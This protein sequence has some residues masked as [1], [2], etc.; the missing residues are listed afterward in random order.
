MWPILSSSHNHFASDETADIF[1]QRRF[2]FR[3]FSFCWR[4]GAVSTT[5]ANYWPPSDRNE[6]R[7][8][9]LLFRIRP[10]CVASSRDH[11]DTGRLKR[12]SVGPDWTRRRA[13][14]PFDGSDHWRRATG[15]R[16]NERDGTSS[17]S[18]DETRP[19]SGRFAHSSGL[20]RSPFAKTT[21]EFDV[22]RQPSRGNHPQFP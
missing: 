17:P 13:G 3:L 15:S 18:N 1:C 11:A 6:R 2:P 20:S 8:V 16:R 10:E 14:N 9:R 22:T 7:F 19:R 5:G 21:V 4:A 12:Q